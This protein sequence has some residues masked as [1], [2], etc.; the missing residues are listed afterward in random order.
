MVHYLPTVI[1]NMEG[2]KQISCLV[3]DLKSSTGSTTYL[4]FITQ[5]NCSNDIMWDMT[6]IVRANRVSHTILMMY[7]G[8]PL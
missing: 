1:Q 3:I 7:T 8:F 2:K 4:Q 5:Q 6:S